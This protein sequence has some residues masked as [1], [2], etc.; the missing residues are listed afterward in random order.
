MSTKQKTPAEQ[1]AALKRSNKTAREVT[2]VRNGFKNYE[3]Y[4]A[5]LENLI[6]GKA[7]KKENPIKKVII[8]ITR[9]K[10]SKKP[11]IHLIDV[12]DSSGSMGG[13]KKGTKFFNAIDGIN[14]G[15]LEASQ[16][17][18]VNYTYTMCL[19]GGWNEIKFVNQQVSLDKV[20]PV[21]KSFDGL[22]ALND[23]LCKTILLAESFPKKDK[24]LINVYT[25]GA[26]NNSKVYSKKDVAN[27]I[28]KNKKANI[29]IT[30][31]GTQNDT[32]FAIKN[33][34]IED[35]NTLVYDGSSEGIKMSMKT[36]S[37]A[38]TAFSKK[39]VNN[40]NVSTGFYKNIVK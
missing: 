35:S 1:L 25:D 20:T 32:D 23:A 11:T 13:Y 36:N 5:H 2:S 12:L 9:K 22:T 34:K 10:E 33:Y 7:P 18:N 37:L 17:K 14:N 3:E 24:V 39:V 40:E 31:I 8:K 16:D 27:L 26:E 21:K 19:F 15:V 29:I 6:S 4:K 28:E 38:R 30:F